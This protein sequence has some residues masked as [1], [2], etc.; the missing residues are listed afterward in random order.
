M[1]VFPQLPSYLQDD[2]VLHLQELIWTITTENKIELPDTR[3]L[4]HYLSFSSHV[5]GTEVESPFLVCLP[6][7]FMA[8]Q[9]NVTHVYCP[10]FSPKQHI[11]DNGNMQK[12]ERLSASVWLQI[13]IAV[14]LNYQLGLNVLNQRSC[15]V[16]NSHLTFK[17]TLKDVMCFYT[18]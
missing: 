18:E 7:T 17:K 2:V 1:A 4:F 8:L 3:I 16:E 11:R 5:T 12:L 10:L 9:C 14:D 6:C 15:L 13:I